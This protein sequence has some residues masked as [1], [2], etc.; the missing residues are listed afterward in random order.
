M[1]VKFHDISVGYFML[2]GSD[3][4]GRTSVICST[5]S[6]ALLGMLA[7]G[8]SAN[9]DPIKANLEAAEAEYASA[10]EAY[11][12]A[13]TEFFDKREE[14][15]RK[16]PRNVKR[17]VDRVKIE[18]KA[19]EEKNEL[20]K[21]APVALKKKSPEPNA[22]VRAYKKAIDEYSAA[23]KDDEA[24]AVEK[25]LDEFN[26]SRASVANLPDDPLQK[27]TVWKGFRMFTRNGPPGEIDFELH[28]T[29]R[30]G[31]KFK[32]ITVSSGENEHEIEGTIR[33]SKLEWKIVRVRKGTVAGQ[34][35]IG[36]NKKG[37]MDIAFDGP[38][39]QKPV[40]GVGKLQLQS[41]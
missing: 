22:L 35:H 29:E 28:V 15:A 6:A 17:A 20:P 34:S 8:V 27:G 36:E 16:A 13:V 32:G 10:K 4:C 41:K 38:G 12:K 37:T 1:I 23:H 3:S 18:R 7:Y 39:A 2:G 33:G 30:V 25:K 14:A 9:D 19:F 24:A 40:A 31:S 11:K 26:K 21:A 5:I